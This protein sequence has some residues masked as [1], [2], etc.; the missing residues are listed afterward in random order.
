LKSCNLWLQRKECSD[1][2]ADITDSRVWKDVTAS[3]SPDRNPT[4]MLGLLINIDWFQPHKHVA[5]SVGVIYGVIIN[6][7]RSIRYKDENVI[8]I[9]IIPGPHEPKKHVNSYLGPL[10][11]ELLQLQSGLWFPTP[12][13]KQF[14][15]CVVMCLSSDIPATRK[16]AGFVGH[17]AVKACSRC[18]KNFPRVNDHTDCSGFNRELWPPRTYSIHCES[19]TRD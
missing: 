17:N 3:L 1:I 14:V 19:H 7:P 11:N 16:A 5:Y 2:L 12:V 18:L 15:K 9:G 6:L 4:N 10:V 8:I 13:V